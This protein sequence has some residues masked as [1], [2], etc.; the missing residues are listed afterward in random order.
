MVLSL[1]TDILSGAPCS[2]ELQIDAE[3]NRKTT[4]L[5]KDRYGHQFM[6]LFH[7][8]LL[9]RVKRPIFIPTVKTYADPPPLL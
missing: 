1:V 3:S 2:L 7:R 9:G 5:G 8:F 6:I 4:Y